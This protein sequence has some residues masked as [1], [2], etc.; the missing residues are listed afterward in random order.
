MS[1]SVNIS[2]AQNG[3]VMSTDDYA[4]ERF[5]TKKMVFTKWEDLIDFMNKNEF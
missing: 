1:L 5:D 4:V 2:K 3:Y